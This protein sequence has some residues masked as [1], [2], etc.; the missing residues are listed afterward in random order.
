MVVVSYFLSYLSKSEVR[1]YA[2]I[3]TM[4][5]TTVACILS[6]RY[7]YLFLKKDSEI[8]SKIAWVYITASFMFVCTFMMGYLGFI[9]GTKLQWTFAYNLRSIAIVFEV[10]ALHRFFKVLR[11]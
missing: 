5:T 1:D 4:V 3:V 6:A 2:S 10:I 11:E 8:S 7:S 9:D